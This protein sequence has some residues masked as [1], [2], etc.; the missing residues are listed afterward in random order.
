MALVKFYR[1]TL[2]KYSKATMNDGIYFATDK[3][4]IIMNGTQFGGVNMSQFEGFIKD[5]DVE[6]SMLSFSK[7]VNGKWEKVSIELLK[8][9]DKSIILGTI[10]NDG[11]TDGSSIKV[12]VKDVGTDDGLK[13]GE[14]GLY[15]DFTSHDAKIKANTD[16]I[17]V[18]NGA[19]T[20]AGSVANSIKDAVEALDVTAVGGTGKVITTVSETDGKIEATAI[21][22]KSDAVARTATVATDDK[23]A[24]DGA[25]VE[26]ALESLAK[27][28]KINETALTWIE[29]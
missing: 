17:G 22:L 23:V 16:A 11:V 20:V 8:A 7:D 9:D 2:D 27:S 14:N 5:V 10:N 3:Q 1:G 15:V 4:L 19:D 26:A 28:V 6:G 21:D 29:A 13:L 24:V 18:L 12:N 25:T